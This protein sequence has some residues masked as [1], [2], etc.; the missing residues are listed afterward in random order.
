[1]NQK[2]EIKNGKL[3]IVSEGCEKPKKLD[4]VAVVGYVSGKGNKADYRRAILKIIKR[5]GK[6][7]KIDDD[8]LKGI[9]EKLSKA[10]MFDEFYDDKKHSELDNMRND[11]ED[12]IEGCDKA[13]LRDI[14]K[15]VKDV[16][17]K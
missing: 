8:T 3:T 7:L 12:M 17:K 11:I 15:Y 14:A 4:E 9:F 6:E 10:Q 2:F 1:M 5:A 13:Q 16:C